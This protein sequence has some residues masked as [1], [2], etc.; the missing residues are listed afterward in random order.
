M[1]K[2]HY[3]SQFHLRAFSDPKSLGQKDSWLWVGDLKSGEVKRRSPKNFA[4]SNDLFGGVDV[5]VEIEK[6]LANDVEGPAAR[7]LKAFFSA[8]PGREKDLP[9]ELTRYLSWAAA[10]TM[11]MKSL[12]QFWINSLA[13]DQEFANSKRTFPVPPGIRLIEREHTLKHAESGRVVSEKSAKVVDT[14]MREGWELQL[15]KDDFIEIVR[16]QAYFF[17]TKHFPALRWHLVR[18]PENSDFAI[19]DRPVFWGFANNMD[20]PPAALKERN[21]MLIACLTKDL[22]L[23]AIHKEGAMPKELFS[24]QINTAVLQASYNWIAGPN[25]ALVESLISA[26][27]PSH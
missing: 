20:L 22:V 19:G 10:R 18:A 5:T 25:Q 27:G 7:A 13:S 1:P 16:F 23:V 15:G 12:Y 24:S 8:Q 3:V 6:F 4:W 9:P 14:M 11:P 2:D 21:I 26:R 17:Q